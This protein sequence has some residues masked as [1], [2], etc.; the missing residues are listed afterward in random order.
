MIDECGAVGGLGIGRGNRSN[1]TKPAPGHS[2]HH[3]S[4][5]TCP[6]RGW[7]PVTNHLSC[8]TIVVKSLE[9]NIIVLNYFNLVHG[10]LNL[11]ISR[12]QTFTSAKSTSL[13]D[14]NGRRSEACIATEQWAVSATIIWFKLTNRLRYCATDVSCQ[15]HLSFPTLRSYG[16][17]LF[18]LIKQ[19][20]LRKDYRTSGLFLPVGPLVSTQ[21]YDWTH[22]ESWP[23]QGSWVDP[24]YQACPVST[25]QLRI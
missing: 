24:W 13:R 9:Q 8:C 3:K 15:G 21:I 5:V 23:W 6:V 11:H 2:V 22:K 14:W 18:H 17:P 12:E 4:N 7:K 25:V 1:W 20:E 16:L 10:F 19:S